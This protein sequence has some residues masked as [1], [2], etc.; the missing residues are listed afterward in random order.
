MNIQSSLS[1]NRLY[2]YYEVNKFGVSTMFN[3]PN[4]QN[5]K[6]QDNKENT[7][8]QSAKSQPQQGGWVGVRSAPTTLTNTPEN[9]RTLKILGKRSL[10]PPAPQ[11]SIQE[12]QITVDQIEKELKEDKW[13]IETM[14]IAIEAKKESRAEKGLPFNCFVLDQSI[15]QNTKPPAE[16]LEQKKEVTEFFDKLILNAP[17][18]EDN[19]RLQLAVRVGKF[20]PD[21]VGDKD[22]CHWVA[23]DVIVKNGKID[24]FVLETFENTSTNA[25]IAELLSKSGISIHKYA[26]EILKDIQQDNISCSRFTLDNLYHLS[27]IPIHE[28]IQKSLKMG[29]LLAKV[30][31]PHYY[32]INSSNCPDALAVAFKN[33]QSWKKISPLNDRIKNYVVNLKGQ[34]MLEFAHAHSATVYEDENMP[35]GERYVK[36]DEVLSNPSLKPILDDKGLPKQRNI[37]IIHK[38]ERFSQKTSTFMHEKNPDL[39]TLLN[40]RQGYAFIESA[41]YREEVKRVQQSKISPIKNALSIIGMQIQSLMNQIKSEPEIN[42]LLEDIVLLRNMQS[43]LQTRYLTNTN[44][45]KILQEGMQKL[46]SHSQTII[47]PI[48]QL[49]PQFPTGAEGN[50][51]VTRDKTRSTLKIDMPSMERGSS[52]PNVDR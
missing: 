50:S 44:A 40:N 13:G 17:K 3:E 11:P 22:L 51:L 10:N 6:E 47:G 38:K 41:T 36:S 28:E 21:L 42:L 18:I 48:N 33:T 14:T 2:L 27:L 24:V 37:A 5:P 45:S 35:T 19:T 29:K 7:S 34:T 26:D 39:Q 1:I 8:K 23:F 9:T 31:E 15:V 4:K 32:I 52:K 16:I 30:D 49:I 43:A 25:L 20:C 46:S 12:P